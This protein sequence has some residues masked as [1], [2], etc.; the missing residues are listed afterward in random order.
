M[1]DASSLMGPLL[2]KGWAMSAESC[3]E[4]MTPL[5]LDKKNKGSVCCGCETRLAKLI[6]NGSSIVPD[7]P[8][9][10]VENQSGTVKYRIRK[11]NGLFKFV[12]EL[13]EEVAAKPAPAPVQAPTPKPALAPVVEK[14]P[15]AFKT[16]DTFGL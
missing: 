2:L 13:A 5:M 15:P 3:D 4:C 7:G 9:W 6:V 10:L 14:K 12:G 11:E 1:T 16:Q 8:L